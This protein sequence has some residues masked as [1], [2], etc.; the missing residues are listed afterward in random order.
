[1]EVAKLMRF[2]DAEEIHPKATDD[3]KALKVKL[4]QMSDEELMAIANQ[5]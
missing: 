5:N 2:Y 1:M 3:S 4:E